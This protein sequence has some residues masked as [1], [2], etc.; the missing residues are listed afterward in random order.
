MECHNIKST[1]E[2]LAR[3]IPLAYVPSNPTKRST[4]LVSL[5]CETTCLYS[6]KMKFLQLHR[7]FLYNVV[8]R[9]RCRSG[10]V[11][12]T[13][14]S[15]EETAKRET[16][17][18]ITDHFGA[19]SDHANRRGVFAFI[20]RLRSRRDVEARTVGCSWEICL[21]LWREWL[22]A[23]TRYGY[24]LSSRLKTRPER[25]VCLRVMF[26]HLEWWI[27]GSTFGFGKVLMQYEVCVH[28]FL[29]KMW[30]LW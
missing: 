22:Y 24:W 6:L 23:C 29:C 9:R 19:F 3:N 17:R 14:V 27:V 5:Q 15:G 8:L 1:L 13:D 2:T 28:I 4:P 11:I 18:A 7:D 30:Q 12:V 25:P 21:R 20:L 16:T 10:V 26:C